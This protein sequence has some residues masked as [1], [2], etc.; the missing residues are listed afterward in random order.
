MVLPLAETQVD[1]RHADEGH[2]FD[3]LFA[4][5]RGRRSV[6]AYNFIVMR[7]LGPRNQRGSTAMMN[8]VRAVASVRVVDRDKTKL[9]KFC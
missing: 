3:H 4:H 5:R 9:G 8:F 7:I 6:A 2:Q 1:S